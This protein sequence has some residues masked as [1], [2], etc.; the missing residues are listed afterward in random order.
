MVLCCRFLQY[1]ADIQERLWQYDTFIPE[2]WLRQ[3]IYSLG[4]PS[5]MRR[6]THKLLSGKPISLSAV[7]GSITAGQGASHLRP[8]MARIWSWIREV[9]PMPPGQ[10]N[11]T[12]RHGAFGGSTSGQPAEPACSTFLRTRTAYPFMLGCNI[13]QCC[14][15]LLL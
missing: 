14:F 1:D 2:R 11:H 5:R 7:G 3:G 6:F 8:V 4:E 12:L 15:L 13:V 9:A 10:A